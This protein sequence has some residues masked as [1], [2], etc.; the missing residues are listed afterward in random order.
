MIWQEIVGNGQQ[1]LV[2]ITA[3][4]AFIEEVVTTSATF[5]RF[6]ATTAILPM[7]TDAIRSAHFYICRAELC[8]NQN[9]NNRKV[10]LI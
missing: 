6:I 10:V 7:L 9:Y 1:K 8:E 2:A 3:I 4:L 5:T